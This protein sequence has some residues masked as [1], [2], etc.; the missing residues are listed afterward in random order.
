MTDADRRSLWRSV[1]RRTGR[2][3]AFL[4]YWL[5]RHRLSERLS[6]AHLAGRLGLDLERL[7]LLSLCRTPRDEQFGTDLAV[8]SARTGA[9]TTA[10]A[11]LLRQ[12]QGLARWAEGAAPPHG[13][14]MAASDAVE[15]HREVPPQESCDES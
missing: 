9:E 13:W 10:L 6:P 7:V 3:P 5:R 1:L 8:V 2:D 15:E 11:R 14:L 4:G 12:E